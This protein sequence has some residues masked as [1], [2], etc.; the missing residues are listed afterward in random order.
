MPYRERSKNSKVI[1][2]IGN[3]TSAQNFDACIHFIEDF[4]PDLRLRHDVIFRI[5]GKI[6]DTDAKNFRKYDG[7][8]VTG[9]VDSVVEAVKDAVIGVCPVRLGAGV[10]NKILEYMALGIPAITSSIGL[11]GLSAEKGNEILVADTL[12]EYFHAIDRILGDREFAINLSRAGRNYVEKNHDWSSMIQPLR[13]KISATL[14]LNR[15]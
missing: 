10:Q 11:E 12:D 8:E 5:V 6:N 3:I 15:G 14:K 4:L 13:D 1:V 7:V 2:F 9:L